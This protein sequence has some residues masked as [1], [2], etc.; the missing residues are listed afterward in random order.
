MTN[1][2]M[3]DIPAISWESTP[4]EWRRYAAWYLRGS[5]ERERGPLPSDGS[6]GQ[7][8]QWTEMMCRAIEEADTPPRSRQ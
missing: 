4:A 8:N 6:V 2:G 7:Y 5:R 3:S 1:E